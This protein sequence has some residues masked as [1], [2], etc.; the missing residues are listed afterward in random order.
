[1]TD[2]NGKSL[3]T[4]AIS[5][6]N[7]RQPE[8]R[9]I[10]SPVSGTARSMRN[11][12]IY[13]HPEMRHTIFQQA[14]TREAMAELGIQFANHPEEAVVLVANRAHLLRDWIQDFAGAK[15]YLLWT[16][17]PGFWTGN[18][19]WAVIGGQKVR[20]ISL[21][22][23]E[24]FLDNYFYA[25]IRRTDRPLP[26]PP[27]NRRLNRT[28]VCVATANTRSDAPVV[29]RAHGIDLKK[30]RFELA[31]AGHAQR[32]VDIYGRG[33]PPGV[34]KGESRQGEWV[35]AKYQILAAYDF[36]LCFE[37]SLVP[38]YCSEKI[39]HAIY[40]G[41][42]PIYFGQPTL[43]E[44]FPRQSVIDYTELGS[45]EVLFGAVATMTSQEFADRYG[46][47]LEVLQRV[48]PKG[49]GARLRAARHAAR[50]M[51]ELAQSK[52]AA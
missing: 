30:I 50:Q 52:V 2:V 29:A 21:H 36:N 51:M 46:R 24:V 42:L 8:P 3:A 5:A 10:A 12:S 20:T 49:D 1:M 17:E 11:I 39:W 38:Y 41:C 34:S 33:W 15:K 48:L 43:Y 44:D 40:C 31:L 6:P 28:I 47:C 16:H 9:R 45:P 37:N 27:G 35:L 14:L 32:K 7:M 18:Q 25:N 23:G 19:K 4:P 26:P 13:P 22:S